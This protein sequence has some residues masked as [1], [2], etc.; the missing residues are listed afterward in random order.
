MANANAK[1]LA[2]SRQ[3]SFLHGDRP[4][5]ESEAVPLSLMG[6]TDVA[7]FLMEAMTIFAYMQARWSPPR[8]YINVIIQIPANI[9][10][11]YSIFFPAICMLILA[12]D[13]L[14]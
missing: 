4:E 9:G 5:R 3:M 14:S 10:V 6:Y 2:N 11:W 12:S 13:I 7:G 8:P 1:S